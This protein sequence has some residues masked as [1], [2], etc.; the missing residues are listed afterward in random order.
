MSKRPKI[1]VQVLP[2][3]AGGHPAMTGGFTILR[4]PGSL[5]DVVY[6]ENMTSDLF[7]ES[8]E[9]VHHYRLAFDHLLTQALGPE[10]SIAF[11]AKITGVSK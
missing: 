8:E 3:A 5:E 10:E 2:F 7:V 1:S 6:V 11:I 9:D 4:F